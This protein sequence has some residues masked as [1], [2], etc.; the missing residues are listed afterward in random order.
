MNNKT[1]E[2]MVKK[3]F[4]IAIIF[5]LTGKI[6]AQDWTQESKIVASYRASQYMWFGHS[7]AIDGDYA[8][9]GEPLYNNGYGAVY[10]YKLIDGSWTQTQEIF[11]SFFT[12]T[13]QFGYS[14]GISGDYAIIGAPMENYSSWTQYGAVYIY[15]NNA[16][17]WTQA[18]KINPND[19]TLTSSVKW[20]LSV[21]IDGDY[22]VVGSYKEKAFILKN[23]SGTWAQLH[24]IFAS[25]Q[26][27]GEY[28]G[29]SVAIE[30]DNAIIGAYMEDHDA[31]GNS[32]VNAGSA[33]VFQNNSGTWSQVQKIVAS[34]RQQWSLF[35]ISVDISGSYAVIGARFDCYDTDGTSNYL[36]EAGSAYIFQNNAGTWTQVQKIVASDRAVSDGFGISVGISG[37]YVVVGTDQED[38]D[39]DGANTLNYAGSAYIFQNSSGT[40]SQS[41]K[42]VASDR[43]AGD[44]FGYSLGISGNY[45]F[46]GAR[47]HDYDLAGENFFDNSGA[48]YIFKNN[49]DNSLPVELTSF[50]AECWSNGVMLNWITESET[51]NLGF[52]IE[53]K[54]VG[55][56]HDSPSDWLQIASYVTAD[57]LAGHG[58]TS[59]AHE[60]AYTD[61]AVQPGATYLYRLAD[62]DYGGKVTYH[63]EVEVKVE[64]EEGWVPLVFGL[65]PAYP[66]PFNPRT[67]ITYLIP[68]PEFVNI[69]IYD[70]TGRPVAVLIN[71]HQ[72]AGT[73]QIEWKPQALTSGIYLIRIQ[74]GSYS[75]VQKCLMVK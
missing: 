20:G 10:M 53:R 56:N 16:G 38:E 27:P 31:S 3:I 48:C 17:T 74:A 64:I 55:A 6:F 21:A 35:G 28:F 52:I 13:G 26:T 62:V 72:P 65:R 8:I 24:N 14:V 68:E 33:Y 36:Q 25:D 22:A 9:V 29:Y 7:V 66:N 51:E 19:G 49:N 58:S 18:V 15:Y 75:S 54:T 34:D 46:I 67:T 40:W 41:Q 63:K 60:Y 5:L 30:G 32:K 2:E 61:N 47:T 23:T 37:N 1:M 73:Y 45:I 69:T 50:S 4:I 42:V 12:N 70:L 59:E 11:T 43:Q 57:A 71:D 44:S 39:A